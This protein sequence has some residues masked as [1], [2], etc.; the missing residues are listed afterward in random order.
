MNYE[1]MR[2][3]CAN[4]PELA[5]DIALSRDRLEKHFTTAYASQS[6]VVAAPAHRTPTLELGLDDLDFF[7]DLP[8]AAPHTAHEELNQYFL[9]PREP[10]NCDPV[11]W[12]AGRVSQ[13]PT[14]SKLARDI[15]SIPGASI[16]I[17]FSILNDL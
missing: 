1:G 11:K 15:L 5:A 3:A 10:R 16:I 4:D 12:W 17:V 8:P 9:L 13:F 2:N 6:A 14:L 7:A